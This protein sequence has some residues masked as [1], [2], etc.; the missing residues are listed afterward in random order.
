M[1]STSS[2]VK[3]TIV[4]GSFFP[5]ANWIVRNNYKITVIA[6]KSYINNDYISIVRIL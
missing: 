4:V 1:G 5:F 6:K 2:P 3:G